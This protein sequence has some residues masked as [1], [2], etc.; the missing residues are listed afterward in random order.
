MSNNK[1]DLISELL[2]KYTYSQSYK[3]DAYYW[4]GIKATQYISDLH[5]SKLGPLQFID[6][7]EARSIQICSDDIFLQDFWHAFFFTI[8]QNIKSIS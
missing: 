4:G 7:V 5:Q 6:I 3:C 8:E 2:C 1:F